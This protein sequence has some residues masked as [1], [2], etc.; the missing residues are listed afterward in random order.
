MLSIYCQI[1]PKMSY[2][3]VI[4][5]KFNI[6]NLASTGQYTE[7]RVAAFQG[8]FCAINGAGISKWPYCK[9]LLHKIELPSMCSSLVIW[10]VNHLYL[11]LFPLSDWLQE[12]RGGHQGVPFYR[13]GSVSGAGCVHCSCWEGHI[14]WGRAHHQHRYSWGDW[15]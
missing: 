8:E 5:V 15:S 4:K 9:S 6:E 11:I 14:H 13:E 2:P 7:L 12:P 3:A 1:T 10:L